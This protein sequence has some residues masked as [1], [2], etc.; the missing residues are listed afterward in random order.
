MIKKARFFKNQGIYFCRLIF[1]ISIFLGLAVFA[2]SQSTGLENVFV[3]TPN[4]DHSRIDIH[5]VLRLS[6]HRLAYLKDF[7]QLANVNWYLN[8]KSVP[9]RMVRSGDAIFFH[10]LPSEGVANV[11][12]SINCVTS[13]PPGYRKRLMSS[14]NF[15]LAR[16]GLYIGMV[17]QDNLL[18]QIEWHLPSGWQLVM[19]KEGK[20]RFETFKK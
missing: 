18:V 10:D 14:K 16:E 15:L 7:G 12:Y 5:A 4:P 17:G 13:P 20:Q 19:G 1:S 8:E 11:L 2:Q 6:P 3:V 9:F